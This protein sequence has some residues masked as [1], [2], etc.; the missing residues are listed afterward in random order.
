MDVD[1]SDKTPLS[2][3]NL[4]YILDK[5]HNT[6]TSTNLTMFTNELQKAILLQRNK[7]VIKFKLP[8]LC[9]NMFNYNRK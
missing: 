1:A 4:Y 8:V 2:D 7:D 9:Q 6:S 3:N 5:N